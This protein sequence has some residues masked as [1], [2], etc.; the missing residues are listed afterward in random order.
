MK[1]KVG[2]LGGTFDPIHK[3]HIALAERFLE[4]M[5]LDEVWFLVTPQNP[6]KK[7]NKLTDD[8]FRL[9]AVREA[10]KNHEHL[11]ASDY[12]FNLPKPSYSY[13]TLRR[14][15]AEYPD[16]EFILLIGADNWVKFDHWAESAEILENHRLAVYPRKGYDVDE[17]TM[18]EG[19]AY[20]N[21][22]LYDVSSTQI[23]S[24]LSRGEDV[25]SLVPEGVAPMLY[26]KYRNKTMKTAVVILNWNGSKMMRRFLP[27]VVQNTMKGAEVWVVD[28]FS[29][30]DSLELLRT[31]FPTVKTLVFEKNWGYAYGYNKAIETIDADY[32]VLL[33]SD[34]ECAP[35]WLEPLVKCL[36]EN[37]DVV[38][39]QPKLLQAYIDTPADKIKEHTFEYAGAAGGFVD[40]FGYPY[41]R[42]RLFDVVEKDCG[43][44]DTPMEIHWATGACLV[45]RAEEYKKA[46]G[47]DGRF[48]AHCEEID[49]CWRLRIA[50]WRIM[51]VP[52]SRVYH[53]GGGTLPQGNPRKTYLNFRNNLTMIYKNIPQQRLK[54][55]MLIRL[56]LDYVAM[57]QSLAKGN[58]GDVK[59]IWNARRDFRK[60]KDNFK[61]DRMNIQTNRRLHSDKDLAPLSLLWQCF[62][63]GKK[64]W[65]KLPSLIIMSLMLLNAFT[66]QADE[67][68]RG[69]GLYPGRVSEDFS[70]STKTSDEYRNIAK[71][72]V[73]YASSSFD[74]NLTAQLATDGFITDAEPP[75]LKVLVNGILP[76]KREREW[77]LDGIK[78]TA[79]TIVGESAEL[80]L[81]WSGMKVK[82]DSVVLN[83]TV[84]YHADKATKGYAVRISDATRVLSLSKDAGLPGEAM[85]W[86]I[87]SDP[88]KQSDYTETLPARKVRELMKLDG[89]SPL[90]ELRVSLDMAGAEY[91]KLEDMEFYYKGK[92]LYCEMLPSSHFQSAWMSAEGGRQ[93][94]Y[95]DLGARSEIEKIRLCWLQFAPQGEVQTSDDAKN[96]HSIATLPT[97][98][99]LTYE[100]NTL[101]SCRY[102]RVLVDGS[103]VPYVLSEIEAYGRGGTV[104]RHHAEATVEGNRWLLNGGEWFVQRAG[105]ADNWIPATVPGTVLTSYVNAG[106]VPNQNYDDNIFHTSESFFNSNFVYRRE[107]ALPETFGGKRIFLNLD[108]IN[109]KAQIVLNGKRVGRVDGAFMRGRFDVTDALVVGR[110]TLVIE[111]EK[112]AHP[113]SVK[114][115]NSHN[116]DTN[117]GLLGLDNPTFHASIGWDWISTVRGRNIGIWNDISL[118]AENVVTLTDP[119]VL[120]RLSQRGQLATLSPKVVVHN[121]VQYAVR[122][123]LKGWIGDIAF[124][125]IIT[126]NNAT[127]EVTFSPSD[128]KQLNKRKMRL[129]WP[130]GYGEPYLYDAGFAFIAENGDTLS[131]YR[132]RQGIREMSYKDEATQLKLYVNGRRVVPLG[133]NWGFSEH[134]LNYRGREYETAVRYHRDMN[135][136]MIRNWVGQTGDKEFYDA[137]DKYGIMVWQDFWLANPADGPDPADEAMF[138]SNAK[139]YVNRIRQHSSIVLYCGRNEGYPPATLNA[140]LKKIVASEHS[141]LCYIPSSA[142]DGVSG[143][144]PYWAIPAKEY[145]EKQTGKFHSERGMPNVMSYEGLRRTLRPEHLWPQS[146]F[147]GQHDYTMAGAQRGATFNELIA[148]YGTID[149][150][151]TFTTLAQ[152]VNYDGYRAMF[153]SD[154]VHRQGL[155]IWMSHACWPSMTW[156]CY[157]YY[158]EP[159]AAYFACKKACEPLHIQFNASTSR[160]EV[161]NLGIGDRRKLKA[162]VCA[163]D[164]NG[165]LLKKTIEKVDALNDSTVALAPINT[166]GI[167]LL[168]MRLVEKK[169]VVS[170]NTYL[171]DASSLRTVKPVDIQP[172]MHVGNGTMTVTIEAPAD[173]PAYMI[174]LN[175][176]DSDGEQILPAMYED[177]YFHLLPGE[178]RTVNITWLDEDQ[179][180]DS[181]KIEVSGFNVRKIV[182]K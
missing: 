106:A 181:V 48:F 67:K 119:L 115:K 110:N 69:I 90:S 68:T 145:F 103:D 131:T 91:W 155:L 180:T 38:A 52:E 73:A 87:P 140:E 39:V 122:G 3:G 99:K 94:L 84:A 89:D 173:A 49:L 26:E 182:M 137:C 29:T 17:A 118:T 1:K 151:E 23:R 139:D 111:I 20:F 116:T 31:S 176:L 21:T 75:R 63:L 157:D 44:Y 25:S 13:Q 167:A 66:M 179:H 15:R 40:K 61:Q 50:G 124:E 33:N 169:N 18:P 97:E 178:K 41:C 142:D 79:A 125:K 175:L 156:Q 144:G 58:W 30:D 117:G 56:L 53:L 81:L 154:N 80:K 171:L 121:N 43:Q 150:A 70:V 24:M 170:E 12:E 82:A 158:F 165:S 55:V 134:N 126:L 112:V 95:V 138:V 161:A 177:N 83:Y 108:G 109:W 93:W 59:A 146:D 28:N 130:N 64:T 60:W 10:L 57:M 174:R 152:F 35:G 104:A 100:L 147:W 133:G 153:E 16:M 129:W 85:K 148:R 62:A 37:P 78:W 32:F 92:R 96:W 46:G 36:D 102:V 98:K 27:S 88:N 42:G 128:F 11:I 5:L 77:C 2:L 7:D 8:T 74:H 136:N 54:S 127:E 47:L 101:A 166:E 65:D 45:V 4:Y 172:T 132:Y 105:G 162:E 86:Q 19:V 120:T 22:E 34:V 123:T 107:F 6:W 113:G 143:H 71:N 135:F 51:C 141:D 159:T 9:N 149:S 160:I 76:S 163:Y 164:I 14:L 168:R 72:H 114:T